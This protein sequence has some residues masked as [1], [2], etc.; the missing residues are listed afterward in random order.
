M[1]LRTRIKVC[2]SSLHLRKQQLLSYLPVWEGADGCNATPALDPGTPASVRC[3][4]SL[5]L[6]FGRIAHQSPIHPRHTLRPCLNLPFGIPS[7]A[8]RWSMPR[9]RLPVLWSKSLLPHVLRIAWQRMSVRSLQSGDHRFH[10]VLVP[11]TT[12]LP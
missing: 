8:K 4:R 3:T 12:A 6:D 11:P 2:S 10:H 5:A 1:T 9:S 7:R